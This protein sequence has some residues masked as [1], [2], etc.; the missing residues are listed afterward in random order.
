MTLRVILASILVLSITVTAAASPIDEKK[1]QLTSVS[2][3]IDELNSKMEIAVEDYNASLGDLGKVKQKL[4]VNSMDLADNQIDLNSKEKILSLRVKAIYK[5]GSVSPIKLL[6]KSASLREFLDSYYVASRIIKGDN[7]LIFDLKGVKNKLKNINNNL[8]TQKEQQEVLVNKVAS[9]KLEINQAIDEK[10]KLYASVKSDLA[11]LQAEE[12]ARIKRIREEALRKLKEE[13]ERQK[14]QQQPDA[15]YNGGN[16]TPSNVVEIGKQY[17]GVKYTWGGTSPETGFDC[18][19][20]V[21]YV[22][23]QTG[24]YLPRTSREQYNFLS[25]KGRLVSE[26]NLAPG[27]LIFYGRGYVTDVKMYMGAGYVIGANG[28]QFTPGE[29]RI[30]ELHYRSDFYAAGRP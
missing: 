10:K 3:A 14:R 18:S 2:Q 23:S 13:Q 4:Q 28:G 20:F 5:S 22:Y 17:L 21:W 16:S 12:R 15:N 27:D 30:L 9:K 8:S 1:S 24:V 26:A 25:S 29:V 19:G 7:Q 6:L 11:R